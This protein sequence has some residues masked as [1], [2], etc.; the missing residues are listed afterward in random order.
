MEQQKLF[1]FNPEQVKEKEIEKEH[2]QKVMDYL[3]KIPTRELADTLIKECHPKPVWK[4]TEEDT[5]WRHY[6]LEEFSRRGL[7]VYKDLGWSSDPDS[8][9][10]NKWTGDVE[11]LQEVAGHLSRDEEPIATKSWSVVEHWNP[12]DNSK[13]NDI[14]IKYRKENI[15]SSNKIIDGKDNTQTDKKY[16]RNS[17]REYKEQLFIEENRLK[18]KGSTI[19]GTSASNKKVIIVESEH[20]SLYGDE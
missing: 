5:T 20:K 19:V 1:D 13:P 8:L 10:V 2:D 6:Y 7:Q 16:A 11:T 14:L 4:E 9:Y 12:Y 17:L 3:S 18:G 15:N